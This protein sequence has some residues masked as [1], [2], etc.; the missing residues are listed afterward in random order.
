MEKLYIAYGNNMDTDRMARRCPEAELLGTSELQG[1]RLLFKGSRTGF[2]ATIETAPGFTVPVV[3]W[4]ITKSGEQRLDYYEGFPNF[5]DKAI[6]K[7][8]FEGRMIEGMAYI[9]PE[10]RQ[11][12]LPATSYFSLIAG[13]Y[14]KFGFDSSILEKAFKDT[15]EYA[16]L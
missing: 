11:F 1:Y 16:K 12:G 7:V 8:K 14:K 13:A 6:L 2:Y 3:L 9:M 4:S 10:G 5:Y 15:E